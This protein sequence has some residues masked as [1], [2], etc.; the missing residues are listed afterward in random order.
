MIIRHCIALFMLLMPSAYR[1]SIRFSR[2][3]K[4][5]L[6]A[7]LDDKVRLWHVPTGRCVKSYTG[8]QNRR[9]CIPANYMVIEGVG[10]MVVMGSEDG[11]LVGWDLNGR[12]LVWEAKVHER[13]VMAV[14][15]HPTRPLIA[16]GTLEPELTIKLHQ[17]SRVQ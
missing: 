16:T 4:Y 7:T 6:A 5:L 12:L 1:S 9:Y 3:G 10:E 17:V 14:A 15:V 13:P 8:H 11:R 2:N